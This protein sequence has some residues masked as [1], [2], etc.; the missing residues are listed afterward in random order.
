[1]KKAHLKFFF[2]E[3]FIYI[4]LRFLKIFRK[5]RIDIFIHEFIY[6][7]N[8]KNEYNLLFD[9]GSIDLSSML[10]S[11]ETNELFDIIERNGNPFGSKG[12][13][14]NTFSIN[15]ADSPAWFEDVCDSVRKS[16]EDLTGSPFIVQYVLLTINEKVF[17]D[18]VVSQ[19]FHF[20]YDA[21]R[22]F[23]LFCMIDT[24]TESDGPF[25]Y[26]DIR[27]SMKFRYTNFF[28]YGVKD[29]IIKKRIDRLPTALLN[30]EPKPLCFLVN[31]RD[32][33]HAGGRLMET[34]RRRML[35]VAFVSRYF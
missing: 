23:K 15:V 35:T 18:L 27:D 17:S 11:K 7:K 6:R 33:L 24:V 32:C 2:V 9:V 12:E 22:V 30:P 14:W 19:K 13:L 29:S 31:T 25:M 28:R 5:L 3:F 8:L 34:G 16:L 10:D 1:M 4:K 20:D 26:Y 21:S